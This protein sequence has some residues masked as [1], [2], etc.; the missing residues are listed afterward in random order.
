MIG[1]PY[2][3]FFEQMWQVV[4]WEGDTVSHL[5]C[6]RLLST[7]KTGYH[8]D[9]PLA[10]H[11]EG[12]VPGVP[13]N[14]LDCLS[15]NRLWIRNLLRV[16][17]AHCA[18]FLETVLPVIFQM[19]SINAWIHIAY[20]RICGYMRMSKFAC[21][22][23]QNPEVSMGQNRPTI[24]QQCFFLNGKICAKN[25]VTFYYTCGN[26][27]NGKRRMNYFLGVGWKYF[28]QEMV[29]ILSLQFSHIFST[30][31]FGLKRCPAR[32]YAPSE[33]GQY[34]KCKAQGRGAGTRRKSIFE[35]IG[36]KKRETRRKIW[37]RKTS[38]NQ[39]S[40]NSQF[41]CRNIWFFQKTKSEQESPGTRSEHWS[42]WESKAR[43]HGNCI[44]WTSSR[45][46][47]ADGIGDWEGR[48]CRQRGGA[49]A[50]LQNVTDMTDISV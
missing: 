1:D 23:I 3:P 13:A 39:L 24:G 22:C 27:R 28:V 32:M 7:R 20:A 50:E 31:C 14:F 16:H 10:I 30:K 6:N 33:T 49:T 12:G 15:D 36:C 37:M 35:R 34:G 47:G 25:G 2:C 21:A 26:M 19:C 40:S 44:C 41:D 8:S 42:L 45:A 18:L 46:C 38:L 29:M 48:R 5:C 11:S 43:K 17:C 9:W 4:G